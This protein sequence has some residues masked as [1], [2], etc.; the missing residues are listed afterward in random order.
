MRLPERMRRA[1][2]LHGYHTSKINGVDGGRTIVECT[3]ERIHANVP[4]V[5]V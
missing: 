2:L 4:N 1:H 3:D 5:V